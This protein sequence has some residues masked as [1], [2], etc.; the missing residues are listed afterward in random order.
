MPSLTK[1]GSIYLLGIVIFGLAYGWLKDHTS[2]PMFL[3]VGLT[4]LLSLRLISEKLGK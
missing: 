1:K 4:Y 2:T 3:I